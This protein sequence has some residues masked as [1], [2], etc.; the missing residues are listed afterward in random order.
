MILTMTSSGILRKRQ[1]EPTKTDESRRHSV[2]DDRKA[3]IA[4]AQEFTVGWQS[5][6]TPMRPF[7]QSATIRHWDAPSWKSLR[8]AKRAEYVADVNAW[9]ERHGHDVRLKCYP[10]FGCAAIEAYAADLVLRLSAALASTDA[11]PDALAH[12]RWLADARAM[13]SGP[14]VA[15]EAHAVRLVAAIIAGETDGAGWLPSWKWDEWA[16]VSGRPPIL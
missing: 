16:E 12:M 15:A 6:G 10:E 11:R 9:E 3:L 2:D 13:Y 8:Q 7:D 14:E 5:D 1:N 4:E